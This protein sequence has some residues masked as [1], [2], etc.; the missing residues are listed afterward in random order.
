MV[1]LLKAYYAVQTRMG[2]T[3]V[4]LS[5]EWH[6]LNSEVRKI[7]TADLQGHFDIISA[8]K[9]WILTGDNQQILKRTESFDCL[10]LEFDFVGRENN[11]FDFIVVIES[12]VDARVRARIGNVQRYEHRYG[13]AET[14][15]GYLTAPLS[16]YLEIWSGRRRDE[17]H[18]VAVVETLFA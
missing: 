5:A 8:G 6:H 3:L 1:G 18:E 17:S 2:E 9:L 10:A 15:F 4:I 14:L 16:H 7:R 11:T 12:A 13:L